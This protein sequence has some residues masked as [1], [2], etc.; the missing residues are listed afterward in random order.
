[1]ATLDWDGEAELLVN[2]TLPQRE[3]I[4][5]IPWST[6]DYGVPRLLSASTHSTH[7]SS[8]SRWPFAR[9]DAVP[10]LIDSG[11]ERG[12]GPPLCTVRRRETSACSCA[13]SAYS[14]LVIAIGEPLASVRHRVRRSS[15][16]WPKR[17]RARSAAC[18]AAIRPTSRRRS[19]ARIRAKSSRRPN[20]CVTHW[21]A[22]SSSP[23]MR[24]TSSRRCPVM[25]MIGTSID[26]GRDD[27]RDDRAAVAA[28][29]AAGA[30]G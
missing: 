17:Y 2:L 28:G 6:P 4:A 19:T 14:P 5:T 1:M 21:S 24:S 20:G 16:H 3:M 7:T 12:E 26:Q 25:M 29:R 9:R 18:R 27:P 15:F 23:T 13:N 30:P 10:P 22:P 8:R 11:Y